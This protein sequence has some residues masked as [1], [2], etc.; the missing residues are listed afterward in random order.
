MW[1]QRIRGVALAAAG[2]ALLC[3]LMIL[4]YRPNEP[5]LDLIGMSGVLIGQMLGVLALLFGLCFAIAPVKI[6]HRPGRRL[7]HVL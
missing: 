5:L 7:R 2:L 6:D 4:F 1:M 3:T